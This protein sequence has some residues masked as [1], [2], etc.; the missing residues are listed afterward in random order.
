MVALKNSAIWARGTPEEIVTEG[1]LTDVF[2][3]DAEVDITDRGTPCHAA[4]GAAR[5]RRS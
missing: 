3:I 5:R 2:D 1:L 4:S